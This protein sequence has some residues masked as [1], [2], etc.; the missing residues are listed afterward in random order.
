L[1]RNNTLV[2]IMKAPEIFSL[3]VMLTL[4]ACDSRELALDIALPYEGKKIVVSGL[5]VSG[6]QARIKVDRTIPINEEGG[7]YF[8][9]GIPDAQVVIWKD[10]MPWQQLVF[11]SDTLRF[12]ETTISVT[13]GGSI[14]IDTVRTTLNVT[15]YYRTEDELFYQP[16]SVY[17]LFV[18]APGYPDLISKPQLY[19]EVTTISEIT[20]ALPFVN[21]Y[22]EL[23]FPRVSF[24]ITNTAGEKNS[25]HINYESWYANDTIQTR[26]D[27]R[28]VATFVNEVNSSFQ[29]Q[30]PV[31]H[32]DIVVRGDSFTHPIICPD[33]CI[34]T[35]DGIRVIVETRNQAVVDFQE[36]VRNNSEYLGGFFSP[37]PYIAHN[38]AGGYGIFSILERD[39]FLL[40]K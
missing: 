26:I 21:E 35:P 14:V 40:F 28:S 16:E 11:V 33:N 18:N 19:K 30:T 7:G 27:H 3:F 31:Q 2:K 23:V 10:E 38:V 17:Q 8:E 22:S 29:E 15:N 25:I 34:V 5:L 32:V 12:Y 36:L 9:R 37:N 1:S 13:I 39:T 20:S 24:L 6:E 4:F